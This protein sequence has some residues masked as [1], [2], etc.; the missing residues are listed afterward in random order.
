MIALA[1][2]ALGIAALIAGAEFLV[3]GGSRLAAR[4]GVPPIVIGLTLVAVGTSTPEL[5]VG[6]EAVR[7]GN[8]ALA[9][10]NI[11]GSNTV[12]I[13]LILGLSALLEPLALRLQTIRLELP[14][15]VLTALLLMAMAWNG[16]LSRAEGA[17]MVGAGLL[18]TVSITY[19]SRKESRAA[20]ADFTREYG[21]PPNGSGR[22]TMRNLGALMLGI[23]MTV[24]GADWFVDG[25]V[26][27]ARA[28]GV[29]DAFIGLTIVA[30]GTSAP[31]LVTTIMG[32]LKHERDIAVG[33][34]I[35]SSVYNILII[36][37]ITCLVPSSGVA[38]D[39]KLILVDIPVMA[40]VALVCVP[41]FISGR[42]VTRVEGGLF[43]AAYLIYLGYLVL[44]RT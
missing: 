24:V 4:L 43:V 20:R 40:A 16:V 34:L 28:M 3:R 33:N 21:L 37:G 35:G 18:Y 44:K 14:A 22:E 5:A 9:V 12:N 36:L 26:G 11:T 19:A 13:L 15:M 27:L 23:I 30:V 6:I 32:T 8:G 1:W 31:E 2:F 25:A 7:S 42:R 17:V 41:V 39:R 38:V 29:S 10:G